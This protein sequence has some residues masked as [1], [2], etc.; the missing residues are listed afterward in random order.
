MKKAS[1]R[2][3]FHPVGFID[4][5]RRKKNSSG[6]TNV[7]FTH[8][9]IIRNLDEAKADRAID[10]YNKEM[11]RKL[12]EME[13]SKFLSSSREFSLDEEVSQYQ[14]TKIPKLKIEDYYPPLGRNK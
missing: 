2:K 12:K 14:F 11:E 7:S 5:F 13:E 4:H 1:P 8:D 3:M 6:N 10:D 9:D